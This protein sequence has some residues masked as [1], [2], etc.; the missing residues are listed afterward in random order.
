MC[1]LQVYRQAY[2]SRYL[3]ASPMSGSQLWPYVPPSLTA[4]WWWWWL[5]AACC[6]TVSVYKRALHRHSH[7]P[8]ERSLVSKSQ[9]ASQI[10]LLLA[11]S[12]Q[13][14]KSTTDQCGT[15]TVYTHSRCDNI[16][17]QLSQCTAHVTCP[18]NG[19]VPHSHLGA[20]PASWMRWSADCHSWRSPWTGCW[21]TR[22]GSRR[23]HRWACW[24]SRSACR[25][26]PVGS[27]T[28]AAHMG[29]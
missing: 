23:P 24:A 9:L 16:S 14:S 10:D 29:L 5:Y 18:I 27:L 19:Q 15:S 4:A 3:E 28:G 7:L 2:S 1:S 11:I 17:N 22:T 25:P 21:W 12:S 8:T 6:V 26:L 20:A 13:P